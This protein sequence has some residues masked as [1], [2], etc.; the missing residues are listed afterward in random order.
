MNRRGT[1]F[2]ACPG[3]DVKVCAETHAPKIRRE[4]AQDAALVRNFL[5]GRMRAGG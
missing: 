3:C 4:N 5:K 1:P 2:Y